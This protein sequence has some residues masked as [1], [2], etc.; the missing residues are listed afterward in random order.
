VKSGFERKPLLSLTWRS[1]A[2]QH[3]VSHPGQRFFAVQPL[4]PSFEKVDYF[5]DELLQLS[6]VVLYASRGLMGIDPASVS[7]S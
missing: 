3:D 5:F 1:I 7:T 4:P 6:P 2:T